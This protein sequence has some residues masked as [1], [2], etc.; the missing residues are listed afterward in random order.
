MPWRMRSRE[1]ASSMKREMPYRQESSLVR[2]RSSSPDPANCRSRKA[3][4]ASNPSS[5]WAAVGIQPELA[6]TADSPQ[7]RVNRAAT[8]WRHRPMEP[9]I[10]NIYGEK[11][12]ATFVFSAARSSIGHMSACISDGRWFH[13]R[14]RSRIAEGRPRVPAHTAVRRNASRVRTPVDAYP[15]QIQQVLKHCLRPRG[16]PCSVT[17]TTGT[18][19]LIAR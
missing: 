18:G 10:M 11:G 15:P 16:E 19:G 3:I 6:C 9:G 8:P 12:P 5:C 4:C 7:Q 2:S 14:I 1:S 17:S 13:N